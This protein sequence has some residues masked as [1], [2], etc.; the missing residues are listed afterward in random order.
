M[1]DT[2]KVRRSEYRKAHS[3]V[4]SSV[5]AIQT[6]VTNTTRYRTSSLWGDPR[7]A[8]QSRQVLRSLKDLA[9]L[10]QQIERSEATEKRKEDNANL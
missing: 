8:N 2:S 4:Q 7:L 6:L 9:I 10:L 1:S 3:A 5:T